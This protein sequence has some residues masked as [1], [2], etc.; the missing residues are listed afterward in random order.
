MTT[1]AVVDLETMGTGP[2]SAIVQIGARAFD[3][4]NG[5]APRS[6]YGSY[7]DLGANFFDVGVKLQTS[8]DAGLTVDGDTVMWWLS[9]PKT[10]Q[11][12]LL[13]EERRKICSLPTA[14]AML[15]DWYAFQSA[16]FVWCHGASFDIPILEHAY[17]SASLHYDVDVKPRWKHWTVRDTRTLFHIAGME[18]D[19]LP[20]N[21]NPHDALADAEWSAAL[22]CEAWK[23]IKGQRFPAQTI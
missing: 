8:I 3:P 22:V 10:A 17:R 7:T 23:K 20:P 5:M 11:N 6:A 4:A 13:D 12:R 14:L 16:E 2:T 9:Q 19:D 1:H 15:S 18:R 21:P